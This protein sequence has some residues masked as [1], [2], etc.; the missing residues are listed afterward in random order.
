M[1]YEEELKKQAV[2]E[3]IEQQKKKVSAQMSKIAKIR[4]PKRIAANRKNAKKARA[5]RMKRRQ[6]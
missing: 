6:S 2:A 3:Y 5:A 4:T 1:T